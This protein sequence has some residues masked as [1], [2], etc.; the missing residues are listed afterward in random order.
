MRLSF[1]LVF[2]TLGAVP[3]Q[4]HYVPPID[5]ENKDKQDLG[6]LVEDIQAKVFKFLD[7]REAEL[8]ARNESTQCTTKNIVF[9]RE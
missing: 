7:N 4:G 1:I 5:H 2:I 8:H 6:C 9:R 3:S